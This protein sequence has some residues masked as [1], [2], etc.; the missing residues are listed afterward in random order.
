M[1]QELEIERTFL[2]KYLPED[3]N[4]FK[5]RDILDMYIPKG[6]VHAKLR[7]R[8][9]DDKY[10]ITKK[11][12]LDENNPSVQ[13]EH[14]IILNEAEAAA[15]LNTPCDPLHKT[16]YYYEYDGIKAEIDIFQDGLKGL[17]MVDFEFNSEEEQINFTMP[18]F[19]LVEVTHDDRIA[20][21][22]LCH[23]DINSFR[24]ILDEYSY[25]DIK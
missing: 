25:V 6:A 4:N 3:L 18:D 2:A 24:T 20:G 14:N 1:S 23:H 19:C 22:L 9:S 10:V 11:Q 15:F 16:R 8:K 5:S 7:I 13:M 12:Q 17:V 21:G